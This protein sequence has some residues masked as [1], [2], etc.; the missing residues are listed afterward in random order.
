MNSRVAAAG[1]GEDAQFVCPAATAWLT[2]RIG[3]TP[4]NSIQDNGGH[5]I[6][7]Y[8]FIS[9]KKY[10]LQFGQKR[11]TEDMRSTNLFLSI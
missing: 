8:A 1:D 9:L 3:P 10:I 2:K 6:D 4:V 11:T 7:K 5:H